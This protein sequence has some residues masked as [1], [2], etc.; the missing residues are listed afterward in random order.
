M[1]LRFNKHLK[2]TKPIFLEKFLLCLKWGK[3]DIL[4]PKINIL[5]LFFNSVH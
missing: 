4:V 1:K 3:A 5:E 2:V